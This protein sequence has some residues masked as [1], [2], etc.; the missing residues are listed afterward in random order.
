MQQFLQQNQDEP[1]E[2]EQ[3]DDEEEE[4]AVENDVDEEEEEEG[5]MEHLRMVRDYE[6]EEAYKKQ[7]RAELRERK[8]LEEAAAAAQLQKVPKE[9]KMVG[10][11]TL[12][13]NKA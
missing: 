10:T 1:E 13:V 6:A 2:E 9:R 4:N 8:R 11:G 12:C 3:K 5:W 7:L